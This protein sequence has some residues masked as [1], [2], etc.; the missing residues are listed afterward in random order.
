MGHRSKSLI[1]ITI[2]LLLA[3]SH[4]TSFVV[5]KRIIRASLNLVDPTS[6]G[7]NTGMKRNEIPHAGALKR[8][9]LL[10]HRKLPFGVNN[11]IRIRSGLKNSGASAWKAKV[12][13]RRK[14]RRTQA[15]S[16]P[17]RSDEEDG[18]R[19]VDGASVDLSTTCGRRV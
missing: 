11:S 12:V 6:D 3:M 4:R 17:S 18:T 19:E 13:N 1:V 10:C 5:L 9:S 2:M 14:R 15:I 8:N 7:T 16:R